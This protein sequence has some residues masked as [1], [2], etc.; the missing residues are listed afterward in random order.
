[1]FLFFKQKDGTG[2]SWATRFTITDASGNPG[3][4][5]PTLVDGKPN[6]NPGGIGSIV[7]SPTAQATPTANTTAT[8]SSGTADPKATGAG[9]S[10]AT[11]L[12]GVSAVASAIVAG[13]VALFAF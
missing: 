9:K 7:P 10:G 8:G 12:G 4:L 13:A 11:T 6:T 5:K 1:Y 3:T 2:M